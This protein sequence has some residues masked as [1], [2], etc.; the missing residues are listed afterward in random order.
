MSVVGRRPD[1]KGFWIFVCEKSQITFAASQ[2]NGTSYG[3]KK[4][5]ERSIMWSVVGKLQKAEKLRQTAS[6]KSLPNLAWNM[7]CIMNVSDH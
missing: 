6:S 5:V 3:L 4:H 2:T 1:G 7:V